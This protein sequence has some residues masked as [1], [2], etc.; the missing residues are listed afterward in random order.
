[1]NVEYIDSFWKPFFQLLVCYG[2]LMNVGFLYSASVK[3]FAGYARNVQAK[4]LANTHMQNSMMLVAR[5]VRKKTV[6]CYQPCI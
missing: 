2:C 5:E 4:I 6:I 1:M 3:P